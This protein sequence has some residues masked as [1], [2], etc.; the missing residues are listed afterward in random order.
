MPDFDHFFLLTGEAN[1]GRASNR[2][3]ATPL[4]LLLNLSLGHSS[5][6]EF[7][8][9]GFL[10]QCKR[11]ISYFKMDIIPVRALSKSNFYDNF[12]VVKI[13]PIQNKKH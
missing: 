13:D 3:H 9:Y 10:P 7:Y 8:K 2:G 1:G 4:M 6:N 5:P 12:P 11:G